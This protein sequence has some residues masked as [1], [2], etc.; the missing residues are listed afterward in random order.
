[1]DGVAQIRAGRR[2]RSDYVEELKETE[3]RKTVG[4]RRAVMSRILNGKVTASFR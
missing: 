1:M 3:K 2:T 4:K